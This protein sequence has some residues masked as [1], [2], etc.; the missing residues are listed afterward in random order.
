MKAKAK[1]G[2]SI[3]TICDNKLAPREAGQF[4]RVMDSLHA[5]AR[6]RLHIV[7]DPQQGGPAI[8]QIAQMELEHQLWEHP[9][10]IEDYVQENPDALPHKDL[11]LARGWQNSI[12][13]TFLVI[14]HDADG[15][16][17]VGKSGVMR[18][19]G[20][21]KGVS[22]QMPE[23]PALV[24]TTLIPAFG[25]IVPATPLFDV[26]R[27]N[28]SLKTQLRER[29]L[30]LRDPKALEGGGAFER[31]ARA[32]HLQNEETQSEEPQVP[33]ALSE[34][35]FHRGILA[36][37]N[38]SERE[39]LVL[40]HMTDR[41]STDPRSLD[42]Q[43]WLVVE[44]DR[45]VPTMAEA[46]DLLPLDEQ[47]SL[48]RRAGITEEHEE[49]YEDHE[50]LVRD[51]VQRYA[52]DAT[53]LEEAILA[54]DEESLDL[55]LRAAKTG[56][57]S[58]NLKDKPGMLLV[59]PLTPYASHFIDGTTL[60]VRVNQDVRRLVEQVNTDE[61]LER[62][63]RLAP[64]VQFARAALFYYGIV[65]LT[66]AHRQYLRLHPESL[67]LGEFEQRMVEASAQRGS[68]FMRWESDGV[69]Y[70]AQDPGHPQPHRIA[71]MVVGP[72]GALKELEEDQERSE[73]L[74]RL[75]ANIVEERA[76]RKRKHLVENHA[77]FEPC[78]FPPTLETKGISLWC[79]NLPAAQKLKAFLD[80]MVPDGEDDYEFAD[81]LVAEMV[82]R[83]DPSS[84]DI[85]LY[86]AILEDAGYGNAS[87]ATWTWLKRLVW[88]LHREMPIPEAYGWSL[89]KIRELIVTE[90]D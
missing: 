82:E 70:L 68:G 56:V 39:E 8:A 63:G 61:L 58:V 26:G 46:I 71:E 50:E 19:A 64:F 2:V 3:S 38:A 43:L 88:D 75:I 20:V 76:E 40:S 54:A 69:A 22:E 11:R 57:T 27:G 86:D 65:S 44:G 1:I 15:S 66:E 85:D 4:G 59:D 37:L 36:G 42:P 73:A 89:A 80:G 72:D 6:K 55:F 7:K 25:R 29:Y 45:E 28:S 51:L 13:D 78:P 67:S 53:L 35:G 12:T 17:F 49:E 47:D 18:V 10:I 52:H 90:Q 84:P 41:I 16:V 62:R 74:S 14:S 24:M 60:T 87:D 81:R 33:T 23:T 5:Y 79:T 34:P 77:R 9:D 32:W 31:A 21:D 48:A 30:H 83:D